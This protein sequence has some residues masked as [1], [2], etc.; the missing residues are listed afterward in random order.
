[1]SIFQSSWSRSRLLALALL[2]GLPLLTYT[3]LKQGWLKGESPKPAPPSGSTPSAGVVC[4]GF[5]D[6]E[7]GIISLSPD[8]AGRVVKVTAE[9]NKTVSA[10]TVLLQL[11]DRRA[12]THVEELKTALDAAQFRLKETERAA[13]VQQAQ[14]RQQRAAAL[15]AAARVSSARHNLARKKELF[16]S[17][18]IPKEEREMAEDQLRET[19]A[20]EL[21]EQEKLSEAQL[22]DTD[23]R[24]QR[25]AVELA[26]ARKRLEQA[27]QTLEG[28]A[29]KAPR[30]GTVLRILVGPG[31]QA[32]GPG[33]PAA[34]L[35]G[36]SAPLFVRAEVTQEFAT[37][38]QPGQLALVEDDI[39]SPQSCNGKVVRV[40]NWFT[41]R[42]AV[43][44]EPSQL[45]DARTVECL[46]SLDPNTDLRV[47]Q[48]VRVRIGF[49]GGG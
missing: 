26:G 19:Q 21:G 48:R 29:L 2:L 12:A 40:S 5:I 11:D 43:F 46:I 24:K 28:Y 22:R 44:N 16:Q 8:E 35:F 14:V 45:R 31:D 3:A 13:L 32:G 9:E 10:G 7:Y 6:Y 30:D 4:F 38:V 23:L 39:S 41:Q 15:A 27:Q 1:M 17:N 49:G 36:P 42:R 25:A 34:I 18:L 20:L 37:Q 47:G 33:K